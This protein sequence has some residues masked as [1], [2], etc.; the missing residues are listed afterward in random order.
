M[1]LAANVWV[2]NPEGVPVLL[3][4]GDT[5]PEWATVGDHALASSTPNPP[6][7]AGRGSSSEA[8][9][10]YASEMGVAVPDEARATEIRAI[11]ETQGIPTK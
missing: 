4:A 5:L 11:L 8:W 1:I 3:R 9:A 6:P 7:M 10:A 2:T